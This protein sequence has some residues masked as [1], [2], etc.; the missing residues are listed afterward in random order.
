MADENQSGV[1]VYDNYGEADNPA[2]VHDEDETYSPSYDN[3]AEAARRPTPAASQPYQETEDEENGDAE[4][5]HNVH[6]KQTPY[7]GGQIEIKYD[8]PRKQTPYQDGQIEIHNDMP[9]KQTPYVETGPS[10]ED[11]DKSSVRSDSRS[12]NSEF[13][14]DDDDDEFDDDNDDDNDTKSEDD[15]EQLKRAPVESDQPYDTRP[16]QRSGTAKYAREQAYDRRPKESRVSMQ[17]DSAH[18]QSRF[19][20][21]DP[22]PTVRFQPDS[23]DSVREVNE[24]R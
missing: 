23:K 14:D 11:E 18:E 19:F 1:E 4:M 6:R 13:D 24:D 21:F 7:E 3:I 5:Y 12:N 2:Y 20:Q 22:E 16:P 8:N 10:L 15:Y 9:R 17:T